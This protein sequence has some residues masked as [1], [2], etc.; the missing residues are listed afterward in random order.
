MK[1]CGVPSLDN[2]FN[3]FK[4]A[5]KK[6]IENQTKY[7]LHRNTIFKES[8]IDLSDLDGNICYAVK[9]LVIHCYKTA[10]NLEGKDI[11]DPAT[12]FKI[13]KGLPFIE[14]LLL[15][16]V[17]L[18]VTL[19][20]HYPKFIAQLAICL[21]DTP[22]MLYN[23]RKMKG[24]AMTVKDKAKPELKA[25][26]GMKRLGAMKTFATN[27]GAMISIISTIKRALPMYA[28]D[29][30]SLK[31]TALAL[32]DMLNEEGR[33]DC[34]MMGVM[35]CDIEK[36]HCKKIKEEK[37]M[38]KKPEEPEEDKDGCST[39]RNCYEECFGPIPLK[40]TSSEKKWK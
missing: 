27:L 32:K 7:D 2:F 34:K 1:D 35:C 12:W 40:L 14:M 38:D 29:M 9:G 18:Y 22:P 25:L 15:K 13:H 33:G 8:D 24:R 36:E 20:E 28:E 26:K 11:A 30:K 19:M 16:D 6:F 31:N 23:L 37:E 10:A 3:E 39:I 17:L 4:K 5:T 21:K